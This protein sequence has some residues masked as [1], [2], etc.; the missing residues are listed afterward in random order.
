MAR[1]HA[2]ESKNLFP[3]TSLFS[4]N[5]LDFEN[6]VGATVGNPQNSCGT[7]HIEREF[8]FTIGTHGVSL[9]PLVA[10]APD[11]TSSYSDQLWLLPSLMR[12]VVA[13]SSK[14]QSFWQCATGTGKNLTGQQVLWRI[15]HHN[16]ERVDS[17]PLRKIPA[18]Q[19]MRNATSGG[20]NFTDGEGWPASDHHVAYQNP[21]G[22]EDHSSDSSKDWKSAISKPSR[23]AIDSL[24]GTLQGVSLNAFRQF[25]I[26]LTGYAK[27]EGDRQG[28]FPEYNR[29]EVLVVTQI[30]DSHINKPSPHDPCC[31]SMVGNPRGG[32]PVS[33]MCSRDAWDRPMNKG[34]P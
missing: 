23:I 6:A 18:A 12:C 32:W 25:V 28:F 34:N 7:T 19:I 1:S 3:T 4:V 9:I 5:V 10:M 16:K 29:K 24:S 15:A 27:K 22:L 31:F 17:W 33:L 8:P 20:I 11:P 30:T 21:R 26:S 14:I 2:M 13:A